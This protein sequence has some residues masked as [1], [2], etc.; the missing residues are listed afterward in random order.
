MY[1]NIIRF[2]SGDMLWKSLWLSSISIRGHVC[3]WCVWFDLTWLGFGVKC[4][5]QCLSSALLWQLPKLVRV[6]S[7]IGIG[8]LLFLRRLSLFMSI[9]LDN[10]SSDNL[11]VTV[12]SDIDKTERK[13]QSTAAPLIII[14]SHHCNGLASLAVEACPALLFFLLLGGPWTPQSHCHS[15][16]ARH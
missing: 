4:S 13:G 9:H 2:F 12:Y 8:C 16:Q 1:S 14:K 15:Y 5:E 7:S 11:V 3:R 6:P 10:P